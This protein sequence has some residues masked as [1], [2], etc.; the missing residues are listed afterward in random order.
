MRADRTA[1]WAEGI[2]TAD[3]PATAAHMTAI[4]INHARPRCD[5][6][7]GTLT[8]APPAAPAGTAVNAVINGGTA[9][10]G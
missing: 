7:I 1:A 2:T 4:R 9:S 10:D 5:I 8:P 6:M 3:K